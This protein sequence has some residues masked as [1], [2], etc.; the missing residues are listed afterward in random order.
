LRLRV[1]GKCLYLSGSPSPMRAS[2]RFENISGLSRLPSVSA[3]GWTW[4]LGGQNRPHATLSALINCVLHSVDE[5]SDK[6]PNAHLS[7]HQGTLP[8]PMLQSLRC[9]H[10]R[11]VL[12]R[13]FHQQ[14]C[15]LPRQSTIS[16]AAK[17][18]CRCC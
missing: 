13:P 10:R 7:T 16:I 14:A 4:G 6:S 11:Q 5:A 2:W 15:A 8:R 17:S 3:A 1:G 12:P 9:R 18:C